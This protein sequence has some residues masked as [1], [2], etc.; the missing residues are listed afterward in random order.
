MYKLGSREGDIAAIEWDLMTLLLAS[1]I[2]CAKG[3]PKLG[4]AM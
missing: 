3:G 4:S 2:G 1:G